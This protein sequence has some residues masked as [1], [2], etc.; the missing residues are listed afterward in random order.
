MCRYFSV[1][2]NSDV[3]LTGVTDWASWQTN[4]RFRQLNTCFSRQFSD[5]AVTQRTEQLTFVASFNSNSQ[6]DF[7][8]L[9]SDV[10]SLC[11]RDSLLSWL[12]SKAEWR[13]QFTRK[14][15]TSERN[16]RMQ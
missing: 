11:F 15:M 5:V 14:L 2:L 4:F 12:K 13:T 10:T 16:G 7:F 6:F 1:Q 9:Q 3:E 8:D